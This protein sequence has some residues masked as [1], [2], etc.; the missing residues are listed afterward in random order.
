MD[1]TLNCKACWG[2]RCA[3][4]YEFHLVANKM[5]ETIP[6]AYIDARSREQNTSPPTTPKHHVTNTTFSSEDAEQVADSLII[7]Y[8]SIHMQN[9]IEVNKSII[10]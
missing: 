9:S 2:Q 6:L 7:S 8:V 3:Y 10:H 4:I 1:Y 5:S